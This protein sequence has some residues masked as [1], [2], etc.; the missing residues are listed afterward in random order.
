MARHS[1]KSYLDAWTFRFRGRTVRLLALVDSFL[2]QPDRGHSP[3]HL[4]RQCN[5]PIYDAV[6]LLD[7]TPELFVKLPGRGD[8]VTRYRL[9]SSVAARGRDGIAA[10]VARHA[11]RET[12]LYYALLAMGLL[13]LLVAAMA[14]APGFFA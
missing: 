8:G 3:A 2:A 5:L 7:Q 10:L 14:I 9:A 1:S 4:A 12:W 11:R 13:L 6:R